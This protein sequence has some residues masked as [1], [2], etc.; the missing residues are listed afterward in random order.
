MSTEL[1]LFIAKILLSAGMVITVTLVAE[2]ASTRFAGVM[3]GFP[4]GAG[5]TFF[6]T[7]IEQGPL[8]AA[9]STPWSIQG[10]SATLVFCLFYNQSRIFCL[11][12]KLLSLA[13]P[14]VCGVGGF[15]GMAY[16]LQYTL[17][18]LPY[19]RA[20]AVISIFIGTALFF[21]RSPSPAIKKRVAATR[22]ILMA[23]ALFAALTILCITAV[24]SR[25]GSAWTGIFAAFPTT[26]LPSILVLHY[27]YG[28]ETIPAIF[29]EIPLGMIAIVVFSVAV[30]L[31]FP[32]FGV[33]VGILVSYIVAFFYLLFY[34]FALRSRLDRLFEKHCR[35][36]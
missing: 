20:A 28:G 3:L 12:S 14:T 29:R 16:F 30:C 1:L 15:F 23:R 36:S 10:L 8:F 2:K 9:Q 5:L 17:A 33:Y 27:H 4:L 35:L 19:L 11:N 26:V 24:A 18:G 34:E 6:F 13:I 32:V 7:G 21:R 31:S 22:Y 25:V